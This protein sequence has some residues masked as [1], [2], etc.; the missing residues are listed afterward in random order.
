DA[1][2]TPA[3]RSWTVDTTPPDTT[4]SAGPSGATTSTSASFSFSS[5]DAGAT[6]E[7]RLDGATWSAC[8][9]PQAYSALAVASHTFDVRAKDGAGN[10]DATPATRT[11]T[12]S[13]SSTSNDN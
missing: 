2:P 13:S 10:L 6:F 8:T 1:A 11:W 9:S 7:C 3:T 5:P 4:I 12:V